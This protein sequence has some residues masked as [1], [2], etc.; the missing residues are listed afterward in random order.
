MQ[1]KDKRIGVVF[2]GPSGEYEVSCVSAST[3][4]NTLLDAGYDHVFAI[5]VSKD[6]RWYGP[7][8][9]EDVK[10]FQAADYADK[11]LIL[12]QRPGATLY[13]ATHFE[14]VCTLDVVFP[15]VHGSYGE[16]GHLQ[17][18]FEMCRLPYVG[19][20]MTGSILGMDKALMRDILAAY[21][22]PQT[23]YAVV[24]RYDFENKPEAVLDRIEDALTYPLFVKPSSSGS[25]VGIS[26][27]ES[28]P[29]LAE[30]LAFAGKYDS[31]LL[32][33]NGVDVREI[34]TALLGNY[35][36]EI[37]LP[38][39]VITEGTFYDYD[40]KYLLDNSVTQVPADLPAETLENIKEMAQKVYRVLDLRGM[41]R[42][43]FFVEK[44]TG[45]ILVNE[46]NTLPGFTPISMYAKMWQASGKELVE[47]IEDLIALAYANHEDMM[48]NY[49]VLGG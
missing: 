47:V 32:V 29:A 42:A 9:P 19:A 48:K 20:G 5:G 45:R 10:H 43:D 25:S 26:K 3:I 38:G 22:I 4:V 31:K 28:R 40:S 11:E 15:I 16:D 6:G 24:R 23:E 35:D 2:G 18:L 33:E 1:F 30:A 27:V 21:G 39:E 44:S 14:P 46:V 37:A 17:A 36:V 12:P 7:V 8:A 49:T 34:E 13:D 41:C